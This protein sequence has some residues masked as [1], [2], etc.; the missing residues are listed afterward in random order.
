M[1]EPLLNA[2]TEL[3]I[4]PEIQADGVEPEPEIGIEIEIEPAV[5]TA[6]PVVAAAALAPLPVMEILPA[7]FPLPLLARFVPDARLKDKA[8]EATQYALSIDVVGV[9]GLQRADTALGA[10]RG[11][12][13]A[14]EVHFEE[15]AKI[16]HDLHKRLTGVRGEW[17]ADGKAAIDAVGRRVWAEQRRLEDLA[18]AERRKLQEEADR[19]AREDARLESER[20]A[21]AGAPATVVEELQRQADTVSAPPV[22][23]PVAA[24]A[25]KKSS[26]VTTWKA[27]PKG[28]AADADPNPPIS[29]MTAAQLD[30]VR[31]LLRSILDG[32]S[33]MSAIELNYSVLNGRAKADKSTFNV[34]G[35]E[36]F[37]DG[38]VRAKSS[39]SAR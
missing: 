32:A 11:T 25:L 8:E 6:I 26:V 24:P 12:L 30:R 9:E 5:A 38:G 34:A 36:A 21:K 13:K 17:L 1:N 39:R 4:E 14:I 22:P 3:E 35:F 10:L 20:A 23:A 7:D 29:Q 15:P 33:P 28:T 18:A 27:R 31:E 19:K 37:E 2:D 16:A